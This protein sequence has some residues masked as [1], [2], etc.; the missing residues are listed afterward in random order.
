MRRQGSM[1][2]RALFASGA[3][4]ALLAATGVSAESL[5]RRG[6]RLRLA[7]SGA[8]RD[9]IF[10]PR[11]LGAR[12]PEGGGSLF[13]QV[14]M[15]GTLFETLT[16]VAADGTLRGEL[17]T[18]WR[19]DSAAMVWE[20]DLRPEARFHDGT[21]FDADDVI[22]LGASPNSPLVLRHVERI[23]AV[24]R[25]QVRFEL[26]EPDPQFPFVLADP[27]LAVLPAGAA[28]KAIANGIGTGPYRIRKFDPGRHLIAERQER[29]YKDGRAGWFDTV[30]LVGIA[31][32]A[33]RAEALRDRYVD[34]ADLSHA[35][36][37]ETAKALR[38]LP[39]KGFMSC[40][41]DRSIAL[42]A[43]IGT[44]WPLDNLRAP[45]RWWVA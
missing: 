9:E 39:E 23:V 40:A 34:A 44:R 27:A 31:S 35:A 17:A 14:A 4:A 24:H 38:Y 43:Q 30:E 1:D 26:A 21:A 20:F 33:V 3:A 41:V 22:A 25:H 7:L 16:E 11:L 18:G 13:L 29:H 45:Q 6:G 36:G 32:D 5:P 28:R 15:V 12:D 2:R 37:L 8:R 42:P 19:S 10:D